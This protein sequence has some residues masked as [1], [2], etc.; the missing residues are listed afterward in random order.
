MV[1][2]GSPWLF[3]GTGMGKIPP[4]GDGDGGLFPDGEFPVAIFTLVPLRPTCVMTSMVELWRHEVSFADG[5]RPAIV[6]DLGERTLGQLR[7]R[8][9][10][11]RPMQVQRRQPREERVVGCCSNSDVGR[12]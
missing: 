4:R 2:E 10:G 1:E 7:Q 9:G 12:A 8:R 11:A 6:A 3:A 5:E